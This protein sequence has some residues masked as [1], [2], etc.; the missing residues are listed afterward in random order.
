MENIFFNVCKY[1]YSYLIGK[2]NNNEFSD[3]MNYLSIFTQSYQEYREEFG[4]LKEG[5]LTRNKMKEA[6]SLENSKIEIMSEGCPICLSSIEPS[7]AA[8]VRCPS[9]KHILHS[10]C[11]LQCFKRSMTCPCCRHD[12]S[13]L[14]GS[15]MQRKI[16]EFH[17]KLFEANF[18]FN[19]TKNGL[20]GLMISIMYRNHDIFFYLLDKTNL[21]YQNPSGKTVLHVAYDIE[22]VTFIEPHPM[23][24]K[25]FS[26]LLSKGCDPNVKDNFGNTVLHYAINNDNET[27]I[28]KLHKYQIT[29]WDI[30]NANGY[31]PIGLTLVYNRESILPFVCSRAR[32]PNI[33]NVSSKETSVQIAINLMN[34][35]ADFRCFFATFCQYTQNNYLILQ[36]ISGETDFHVAVRLRREDHLKF[37][38]NYLTKYSNPLNFI[39]IQ[40]NNGRTPFYRAC[41]I[42]NPAMALLLKKFGANINIPNNIGITPQQI[43]IIHIPRFSYK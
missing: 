39:D 29:D 27:A 34:H 10:N 6:S 7:N 36:N 37:I 19:A 21:D 40:D 31:T 14:T 16:D 2:Y 28:H 26:L 17:Q 30:P 9:K 11:A 35:F 8:I 18:D 23:Q 22:T 13:D 15:Y 3:E 24:M 20:N 5:A 1:G 33:A 42:G 12:L 41:E 38:L 4:T 25:F 43:S 32:F